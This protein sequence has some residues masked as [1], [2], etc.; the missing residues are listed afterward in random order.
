M[1]ILGINILAG[2]GQI[3]RLFRFQEMNAHAI[4]EQPAYIKIYE[5]VGILSKH[6]QI[7]NN[8]N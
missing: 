7:F 1:I 8:I 3:V 2:L 4:I 5:S 6:I